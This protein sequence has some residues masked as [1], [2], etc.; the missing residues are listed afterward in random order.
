MESDF[1]SVFL[2]HVNCG[3]YVHRVTHI[4]AF[5]PGSDTLATKK[6]EIQMNNSM[7]NCKKTIKY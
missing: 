7:Y 5:Y 4:T 6:S 1:I 2:F 3:I